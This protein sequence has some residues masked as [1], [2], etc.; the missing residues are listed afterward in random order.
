[1]GQH[2]KLSITVNPDQSHQAQA[3]AIRSLS[4]KSNDPQTRFL[5]FWRFLEGE[6]NR[7]EPDL[8]WEILPADT[9]VPNHSLLHH[10][11][12]VSAFAAV[13]K[14]ATLVFSIGPV[15]GFI[16]TARKTRDLWMGSYLLSYLIWHAIKVIAEKLGPDNLIY[17]SL[18]EQPL[19]DF[20]LSQKFALGERP[21]ESRLR[22]ATFPNKFNAIVPAEQAESLA[23]E[24]EQ[25]L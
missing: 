17:P 14:P 7:Q 13:E 24:C 12:V 11:R 1:S 8:D 3:E 9:R 21:E 22:L 16:A 4:Q 20:W 6:L 5:L 23:K 2:L 15:Q 19:V 25:A 18:L 10:N